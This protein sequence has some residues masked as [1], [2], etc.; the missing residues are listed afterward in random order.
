M[1]ELMEQQQQFCGCWLMLA[2]R[3]ALLLFLFLSA[4]WAPSVSP[5]AMQGGNPVW[6]DR[7]VFSPYPLPPDRVQALLARVSH[8]GFPQCCLLTKH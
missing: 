4:V 8:C 3:V 1:R 5:Q 2:G 7:A 6:E